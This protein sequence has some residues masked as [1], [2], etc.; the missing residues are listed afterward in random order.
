MRQAMLQQFVM[1]VLTVGSKHGASADQAPENGKRGFQN[2]QAERNNWN[3]NRNNGGSLLRAGECESTQEKADE[4]AAGISPKNSRRIK[5]VAQ[6][7]E[8]G[9]SQ[10]NGHHRDK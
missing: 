9:A 2:R 1:D 7:A 6:E 4:E 10:R 3:R 5:V 8:D